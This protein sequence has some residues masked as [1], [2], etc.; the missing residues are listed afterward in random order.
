MP[1]EN[2]ALETKV[3]VLEERLRQVEARLEK[4]AS[5]ESIAPLQKLVYG[6]V[7]AVLL[8]VL[9]GIIALVIPK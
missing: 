3:A 1:N 5:K 9:G 4:A 6:M 8:A 7:S 2:G